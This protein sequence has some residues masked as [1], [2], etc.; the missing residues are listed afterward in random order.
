MSTTF[1]ERL[2]ERLAPWDTGPKIAG[3]TDLARLTNALGAMFQPALGLAEEQGSDGTPST[4]ANLIPNPS[5]AHDT[6]LG[7]AAGWSNNAS[8]LIGEGATNKVYIIPG[9]S[10]ATSIFGLD[11]YLD[12]STAGSTTQEGAHTAEILPVT[13]GIPIT[14]HVSLYEAVAGVKV[15]LS[16][17]SGACGTASVDITQSG[18]T[19]TRHSVTLTPSASGM[20]AFSVGTIEAAKVNILI[21]AVSTSEPYVDGDSPG[22]EWSGV[23]GDSVTVLPGYVPGF[24]TLFNVETCPADALA[25]LGM[26]VGTVIPVGASEA[27]AR[28]I[29]EAHSGFARGTL[30][31]M[32]AAI[33][34][35]LGVGEP[36]TI[37]ERTNANGEPDAYFFV[38]LVPL[39]K[40]SNALYEAINSVKP[41]GL[42]YEVVEVEGAWIEGALTWEGVGAGV[43][44]ENVLPGEF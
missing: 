44:W 19:W 2:L 26:F 5:F 33:E 13:K 7:A 39:G 34:R 1:G 42:F 31:L 15:R 17:G 29:L 20:V 22:Y 11:S 9:Y 14:V 4:T 21:A 6:Y 16:L 37:E 12:I 25:Y 28:A 35:V 41:A 30:A 8:W 23:K 43:T 10:Q 32:E 27:E 38:V 24:G 36:F 40:A 3:K 18:S